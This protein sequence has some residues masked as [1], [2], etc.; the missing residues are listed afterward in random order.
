MN[1]KNLESSILEYA[2][3]MDGKSFLPLMNIEIKKNT[4]ACFKFSAFLSLVNIAAICST[5]NQTCWRGMES[6][7]K[8]L[9]KLRKERSS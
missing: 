9:K 3:R 4:L 1:Y 6:I 2:L 8:A 7:S 5:C